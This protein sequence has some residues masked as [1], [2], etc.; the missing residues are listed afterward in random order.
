MYLFPSLCVSKSEAGLAAAAV[1]VEPPFDSGRSTFWLV[2][3]SNDFVGD[4]F[5]WVIVGI[6]E[7]E[8]RT[9]G[10]MWQTSTYCK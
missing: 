9:F 2:M 4:F 10:D 1:P 7:C 5:N 6:A 8:R 3:F